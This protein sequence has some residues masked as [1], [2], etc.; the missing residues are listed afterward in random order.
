MLPLGARSVF[1]TELPVPVPACSVS[2]RPST[3]LIRSCMSVAVWWF[4][5]MISL[6]C[7]LLIVGSERM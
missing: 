4:R 7:F 1:V 6:F 5:K 3:R 2:V